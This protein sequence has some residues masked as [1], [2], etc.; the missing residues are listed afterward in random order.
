MCPFWE[1]F[2]TQAGANGEAGDVLFP[3]VV[4][5]PDHAPIAI[6]VTGSAFSNAAS[7][8]RS[9]PSPKRAESVVNYRDG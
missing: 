3:S 4:N 8:E 7:R 6:T 2:T 1:T 5:A 9:A